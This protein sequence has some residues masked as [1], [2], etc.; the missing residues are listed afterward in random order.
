MGKT[1]QIFCQKA[2]GDPKGGVPVTLYNGVWHSLQIR[3]DT[4][5]FFI[6]EPI[7]SSRRLQLYD[8]TY[9][10]VPSS[11]TKERIGARRILGRR[12]INAKRS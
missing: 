3:K 8:D 1:F 6:N 7:P 10:V 2:N 9:R 4:K 5:D 12:G 11:T